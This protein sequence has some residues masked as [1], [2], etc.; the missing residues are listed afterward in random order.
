M[1]FVGG[2]GTE[3]YLSL[4]WIWDFSKDRPTRLAV[5]DRGPRCAFQK[6]EEGDDESRINLGW[7]K[8]P[9]YILPNHILLTSPKG[10]H[11][12]FDGKTLRSDG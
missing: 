2:G 10:K 6:K 12:V 4:F 11:E 9:D 7:K 5:V 3:I 8:N 1:S